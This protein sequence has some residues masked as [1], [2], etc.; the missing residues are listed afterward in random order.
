M[1]LSCW[2]SDSAFARSHSAVVQEGFTACMMAAE[3]GN[4]ALVR[5]LQQSGAEVNAADQ[6]MRHYHT[7]A[8]ERLVSLYI[9]TNT[10]IYILIKQIYC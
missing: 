5:L 6:V 10:Y 3:N 7:A 4:E 8:Y 9:C 1:L 2:T